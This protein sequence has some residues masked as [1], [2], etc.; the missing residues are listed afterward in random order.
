MGNVVRDDEYFE[1]EREFYEERAAIMQ[2]DGGLPRGEAERR[3][4]M[5]TL[6]HFYAGDVYEIVRSAA[7]QEVC[8]A[9]VAGRLQ[10]TGPEDAR[11]K[12]STTL[13]RFR[14]ELLI[15]LSDT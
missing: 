14:L 6:R 10:I 1:S 11:R 7:A 4:R 15:A 13:D 12:W 9:V 2:Y 3:A 5:E 8:I